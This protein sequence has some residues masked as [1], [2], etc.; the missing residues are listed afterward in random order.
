MKTCPACR[1]RIDDRASK[2]AFCH[3]VFDGMQM[4]NGRRE[5]LRERW[6]EIFIAGV[7]IAVLFWWLAQPGTVESIARRE[8]ES[9]L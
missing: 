7:L 1:K 8:V 9:G 6:R 5:F 3:T 4:E 2:C